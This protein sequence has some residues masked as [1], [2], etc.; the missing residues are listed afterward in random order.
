MEYG[1]SQEKLTT[2]ENPTESLETEHLVWTV[3]S[4]G[5]I[6]GGTHFIRIRLI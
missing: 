3:V 4:A 1:A 2:K 6:T 5:G